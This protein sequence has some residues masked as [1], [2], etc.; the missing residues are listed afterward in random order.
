[1]IIRS[2]SIKSP[3][4]ILQLQNEDNDNYA[5][6]GKDQRSVQPLPPT[7]ACHLSC[8]PPHPRSSGPHCCAQCSAVHSPFPGRSCHLCLEWTTDADNHAS[9]RAYGRAGGRR[10]PNYRTTGRPDSRRPPDYRCPHLSALFSMSLQKSEL[11]SFQ[12]SCHCVI[13]QFHSEMQLHIVVK[14]FTDFLPCVLKHQASGMVRYFMSSQSVCASCPVS[15]LSSREM[16]SLSVVQS[17]SRQICDQSSI[18]GDRISTE[19]CHSV[20][21]GNK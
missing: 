4:T 6:T 1:M 3:Q 13:L 5:A 19:R 7:T 11:C 9:G 10:Q 16:T 2:F 12:C 15:D 20:S 21:C 8:L 17:V 18:K 14:P